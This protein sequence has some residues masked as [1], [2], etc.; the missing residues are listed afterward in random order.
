[1]FCREHEERAPHLALVDRSVAAGV[2]LCRHQLQTRADRSRFRLRGAA[3]RGEDPENCDVR[4][5]N[6]EAHGRDDGEAENHGHQ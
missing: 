2:V 6:A 1:M 5:E 4:G 3:E